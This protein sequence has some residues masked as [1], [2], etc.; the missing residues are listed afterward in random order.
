[1]STIQ[2]TSV[3]IAPVEKRNQCK[4]GT[5]RAFE[6]VENLHQCN[7][8]TGTRVKTTP[9]PVEKLHPSNIEIDNKMNNTNPISQSYQ[10]FDGNDRMDE[11]EAYMALIRDNIDYDIMKQD[12]KWRYRDMYEE[13]YQI[14][15]D[16]VC[17][18]RQV[19]RIEG[20]DYPYSLV[21]SKFLK[22]NKSHL[23]YVISCMERNTTKIANIKAYLITAL[24]NAPNTIAHFYSAEVNHDMYGIG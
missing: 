3:N 19:I 1:M 16:V 15:C 8:D 9:V 23:E 6:P 22:L 14:I 10:R 12:H 20:E 13:L 11:V 24:Y 18:P 17:V 21:K 7:F 4:N 5:S 2:Y